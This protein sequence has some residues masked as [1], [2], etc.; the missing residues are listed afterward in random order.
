MGYWNT[1]GPELPLQALEVHFFQAV[2]TN[3]KQKSK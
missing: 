2:Q 3:A 1:S